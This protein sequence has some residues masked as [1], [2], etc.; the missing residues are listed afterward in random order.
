MKRRALTAIE[1]ETFTLSNSMA[2]D[3][4]RQPVSRDG[5]DYPSKPETGPRMAL[6]WLIDSLAL[7]GAG[8]AGVYVSDLLDPVVR[9]RQ[10]DP[11]E[12]LARL[13][14]LT[15]RVGNGRPTLLR[16]VD[17]EKQNH[18]ESSFRHGAVCRRKARRGSRRSSSS[19]WCR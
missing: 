15:Y 18:H 1:I 5:G 4:R 12:R 17:Q 16:T 7:S 13:A 9:L 11:Q 6:R 8:M 10:P 2:P 19:G 3:E 14:G